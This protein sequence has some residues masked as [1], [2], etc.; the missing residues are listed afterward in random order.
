MCWD[1]NTKKTFGSN[2][3]SI[4][5]FLENG[6]KH[7]PWISLGALQLDHIIQDSSESLQ[8]KCGNM[9]YA[10]TITVCLAQWFMKVNFFIPCALEYV[11]QKKKK[12]RKNH[13]N[14]G[15]QLGF[16]IPKCTFSKK[17]PAITCK[18]NQQVIRMDGGV[19]G[20]LK[21]SSHGRVF[22]ASCLHRWD[23][24]VPFGIVQKHHGM[25]LD[26]CIFQNKNWLADGKSHVDS[27]GFGERPSS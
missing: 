6:L 18:L 25:D 11:H 20:L 22:A 10:E 12:E 1:K 23:L 9:Q 26:E 5:V 4:W 3:I 16:F 15:C 24:L 21:V 14:S 8:S 19:H 13:F 27:P 2:W 17:N 7:T